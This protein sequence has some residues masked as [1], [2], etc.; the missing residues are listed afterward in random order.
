LEGAK[1]KPKKQRRSNVEDA[2]MKDIGLMSEDDSEDEWGSSGDDEL[3]LDSD[4]DED[5]ANVGPAGL[6]A[7]SPA[8]HRKRLD[9]FSDFVGGAIVLLML[10]FV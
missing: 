2:I 4:P 5:G 7:H 1:P 3:E 10:T 6:G 8:L 9:F